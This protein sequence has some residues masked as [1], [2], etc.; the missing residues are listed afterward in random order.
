MT[1]FFTSQFLPTGTEA[2]NY[3]PLSAGS[4]VV[5][6]AETVQRLLVLQV[7]AQDTKSAKDGGFPGELR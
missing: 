3:H 5:E 4:S 2:S 1:S 6:C 7:A